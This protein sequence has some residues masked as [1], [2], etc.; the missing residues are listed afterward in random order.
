MSKLMITLKIEG[1]T[2]TIDEIQA[3][4]DL[5]DEEIDKSF[6]LVEI[7]PEDS[8]YTILV[9]ETAVAKIKPD[10]SLEVKGPYS[11]PRIAPFGPPESSS[12]QDRLKPL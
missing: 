3:K 9:V 7:D 11:N 6:G 12:P 10:Q 4:Y 2:P 1:A 5:A 8:L